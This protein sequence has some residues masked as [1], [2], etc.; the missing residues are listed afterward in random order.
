MLAPKLVGLLNKARAN[1]LVRKCFLANFV[2]RCDGWGDFVQVVCL[3]SAK[4]PGALLIC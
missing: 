1:L 2:D 4:A 3:I